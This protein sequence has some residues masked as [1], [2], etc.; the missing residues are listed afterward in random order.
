MGDRALTVALRQ[1]SPIPLDVAF[2][3]EPGE[4]LALFGPS[5]SGKTTVLR[6][7]AGLYTPA[8]T[9]VR[10]GTDV[11]SDT[12]A[13]VH[14]P[15]HLRR[16]GFVPQDAALFPHLGVVDNVT[17]ALLHL[18]RAERRARA[19]DVL[20][21]VHLSHRLGRRPADLS[22]GERQRLALAR[23][24]ARNPQVLLLDEPFA[25]LDRRLR[26]AL[27]AELAEVRR[28]L[29][30][31]IVLVTHDQDDVTRMADRVVECRMTNDE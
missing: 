11:W 29:D 31:P 1:R 18:P 5:G 14:V 19:I 13:G 27:H 2:G 20:E 15:V 21:Q 25:A 3:V 12:T 24:L 10:Y 4:V 28:T 9:L 6:S 30:V 22:G 7:I 17:I 16:L 26:L 8:S 23:A